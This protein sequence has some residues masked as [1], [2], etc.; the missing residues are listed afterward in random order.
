MDAAP[1][2][3][4]SV[5]CARVQIWP[6]IGTTVNHLMTRFSNEELNKRF[7]P[8]SMQKLVKLSFDFNFGEIPPY[9][10]CVRVYPGKDSDMLMEM[11]IKV[12]GDQVVG[13]AVEFAHSPLCKMKMVMSQ[14][15]F[16]G[17][18]RFRLRPLVPLVPIV[19][20]MS[21]SMMGRPML[22]ASATLKLS[23]LL[24]AFDFCAVPG[25]RIMRYAADP[26]ASP[27]C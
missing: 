21:I 19:S 12:A 2:P 26:P 7:V 23:P 18:M 22:D 5:C 8:N 1:T 14:M 13:G 9:V 25:F 11:N 15:Q 17:S 4:T 10:E 3:D 16:V 24:P 6:R 20:G 27:Y